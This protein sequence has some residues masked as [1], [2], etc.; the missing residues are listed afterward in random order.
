MRSHV[1]PNQ[2]NDARRDTLARVLTPRLKRDG[3]NGSVNGVVVY[4]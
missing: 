3:A 4:L 2:S 1:D